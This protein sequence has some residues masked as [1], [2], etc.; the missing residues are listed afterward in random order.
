[1]VAPSS[2]V[3]AREGLDD[4]V[5]VLRSWGL[6][7]WVLPN[8]LARRGHLAGG[9]ESR[10]D[11]L[12]R[13]LRDPDVRGVFVARG[14][15]GVTRLLD[16]IAWDTLREDPKVI[17][18]FSDTSALLNAAWNHL[19]LVT[20]H[21]PSVVGL[22]RQGAQQLSH[23]RRLLFEPEPPGPIP[24]DGV[25]AITEGVAVGPLIGGNLALLTSM[26]GTPDLPETAGCVLLIEDV[27]EVPYRL[28]RMLVHLRRCGVLG[29][30][31]GVIVGALTGCEPPGGRPSLTA[32]EVVD[33]VLGALG[34]PCVAG[35]PVGHL[36]EQVAVPLGARVRVDAAA[37]E[38]L[39]LEPAVS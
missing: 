3:L 8:V 16:R 12:H 5:A 19:D 39:L 26:V 28:D 36:D 7:P 6:E 32:D 22:T 15:Y 17:V 38:V 2:P 14:G 10:L 24:T 30:V 9:D 13:A 23:L 31:A 27:N 4:G 37:G 20:V 34:V 29:D 35:L 25:R 18:G 11:D 21:G 33:D 1:V